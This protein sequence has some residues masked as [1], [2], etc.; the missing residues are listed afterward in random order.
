MQAGNLAAAQQPQNTQPS[1]DDL[2]TAMVI[3][4]QRKE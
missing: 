1:A 3:P 4:P 2:L